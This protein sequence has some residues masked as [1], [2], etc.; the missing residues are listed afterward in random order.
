[1]PWGAAAAVAGS[2]VG[3]II[4]GDA[5]K[6]AA[7]TSAEA[8]RYAADQA[9]AAAKFTPYNVTTGFG[10][11]NFGTDASGK[12]TASYTLSPEMTAIRDRTIAQAGGYDPTKVGTAAQPLYGG[13][14]SL[15]NLGSQYLA[16][17]P[18]DAARTYYNQQRGLFAPGDE[19]QLAGLRNQQFQTGRVG[20]ATGGT[21][22]GNLAQTNPEMAAYY[23][24]IAQRDKS[25]AAQA[26]EYG[27][28]RSAY[29]A[30]LFGT[31]ANLL[32]QVPALT[33]AGYGPLST[34][35][36][37]A[38]SVEGY[39]Q[40]AL[41]IGAQLGGRSATAGASV[42]N[43]LLTGGTNAARTQQVGNAYSPVGTALQGFGN[44]PALNSW[45]QKQIGGG[46]GGNSS[47]F[48]SS[49]SGPGMYGTMAP[50]VAAPAAAT[51]EQA[52]GG[53]YGMDGP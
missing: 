44:S 2:V 26:D 52:F 38:G 36:G 21:S 45:F 1:M 12:P 28:K 23:N 9:A 46:S 43:A 16:T 49:G 3:G 34:M 4:Q 27:M 19:Q 25:L 7:N 31:G 41:D 13:A 33:S 40:N 51:W 35:L 29:G 53:T 14:S 50:G 6:S 24:S 15:F 37:V 8:Q 20:L 17:S 42:A 10:S 11:S 47:W 18:E 5:A 48:G 22:A 30:S 32:G 39:G